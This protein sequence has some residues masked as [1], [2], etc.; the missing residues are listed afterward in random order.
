MQNSYSAAT[1]KVDI[2]VNT[3][4]LNSLTGI[5]KLVVAITEDSIISGQLDPAHIPTS[6]DSNYVHRHMFR[7]TVNSDFGGFISNDPQAGTKQE[8]NFTYTVPV[9]FNEKNCYIVAYVYNDN[10]KEIVQVGEAKIEE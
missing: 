4:F 10:T 7:G 6:D 3:E 1:R 8:K 2:N 9:N 5:Y